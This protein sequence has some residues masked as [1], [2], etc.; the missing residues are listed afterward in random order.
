VKNIAWISILVFL[1]ACQPQQTTERNQV[2]FGGEAQGTTYTVKYIGEEVES[3]P[4]QMD[5]LLKAIDASMSTYL[6]SSTIVKLNK[7]DSAEVEAIFVDVFKLSKRMSHETDGAFDPTLAP[8]IE[9][10]GFDFSQP[11]SM[12]SSKVDSLLAFC[13]FE[14]FV[15]DGRT[16]H[17]KSRGAKLN[18][19]AV[20]QGYSV[21]LMAELLRKKELSDYYVELGGE[22]IAAGLNQ[23]SVPWRIGI[24]KPQG[25]NLERELSAIVSLEN[26]AMVTS[27]NYRKSLEVDGRKYS[28][29]IDPKTGFPVK[30][31]LLSVTIL[32]EEAAVADAV[33]TACMVMG[34]EKSK[35]FLA[36]NNEYEAIF[37]YSDK[38]GNLRTFITDN[39][40]G[41]VEELD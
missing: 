30:H 3:I 10:W 8:V 29:S 40:A 41:K 17:K 39:L 23:D 5:S 22:V 37:I 14:Q 33:A 13:G 2:V 36:A 28:H 32:A 27:G 38:E 11:Q 7:G 25:Q 9:A 20:A 16:L 19:N 35:A 31:N 6:E 34:L 26:Q 15:L 24:D 12:D 1:V 18:F 4:K 21:D